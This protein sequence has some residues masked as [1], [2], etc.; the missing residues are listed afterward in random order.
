MSFGNL[1]HMQISRGV[2]EM[3]STGRSWI[4]SLLWERSLDLSQNT[5]YWLF[6]PENGLKSVSISHSP[7]KQS[8]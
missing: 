8:S 1:H 7:S 4:W 2:V 5:K 3:V 6:V